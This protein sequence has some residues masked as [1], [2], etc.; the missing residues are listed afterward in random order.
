MVRVNKSARRNGFTLIELLVVIAIIAILIG[1]LLP[2]V[3]KVRDAANRSTCSNNMKQL[4][5]AVHNYHTAFNSMPLAEGTAPPNVPLAANTPLYQLQAA[6]PGTT[7]TVFWYLLPYLE[8]DT[9]YKQ[10]NDSMAKSAATGIIPATQPLKILNCPGDLSQTTNSMQG[11]YI[12]QDGYASTSYAAN[13]LVFDPRNIQNITVAHPDGTSN[14]VMF[15]DRFRNCGPLAAANTMYGKAYASYTQSAWGFNSLSAN[16]PVKSPALD[17]PMFGPSTYQ[18]TFGGKLIYP[19]SNMGY[20]P[21]YGTYSLVGTQWV[22]T[23]TGFQVAATFQTCDPSKVQGGHTGSKQVTLSDG[24]VRGVSQGVST[25][26][27]YNACI[28]NDT[29]IPLSDW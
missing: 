29:Q 9:V 1:L 7:G 16:N 14:T 25:Q 2:A 19:F 22:A 4:G 18:T 23:V 8:Q 12:N 17:S 26:S 24:S 5:L 28:P 11:Q 20:T 10:T 13:V 6:P 3:Q 21:G 27:W 15:A